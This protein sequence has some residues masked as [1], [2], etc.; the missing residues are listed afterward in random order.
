MSR[1]A[2]SREKKADS[3]MRYIYEHVVEI[4]QS[5]TTSAEL[6]SR[7]SQA[8]GFD[9]TPNSMAR[10]L[11]RAGVIFKR[12]PG[13]PPQI[14][15]RQTEAYRARMDGIEDRLDKLERAVFKGKKA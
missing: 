5:E 6:A 7:A 1:K 13:D 3:L 14:A 4:D 8:L 10:K 2:G 9:V 12:M 11:D 15:W